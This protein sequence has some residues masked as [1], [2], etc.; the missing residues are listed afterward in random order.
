MDKI[1][2]KLKPKLTVLMKGS[3]KSVEK[4]IVTEFAK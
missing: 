4:V 3:S 2:F 1:W